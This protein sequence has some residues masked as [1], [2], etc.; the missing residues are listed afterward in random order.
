MIDINNINKYRLNRAEDSLI[1]TLV[2]EFLNVKDLF[3]LKDKFE[4]Q[5]F[6][7]RMKM[8]LGAKI[9]CDNF[10]SI[11]TDIKSSELRNYNP[12]IILNKTRY[13]INTFSFNEY[14]KIDLD[15]CELNTIFVLYKAPN[16]FNII[17]FSNAESLKKK[18]CLEESDNHLKPK[19]VLKDFNLL[20]DVLKLKL[21]DKD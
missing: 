21:D 2:L 4:G 15:K 7:D 17:G 10:F 5:L 6:Y 3:K 19:Y 12:T 1:L 18:L 16:S 20:D 14:P 8:K 11:K 9:S 13:Y